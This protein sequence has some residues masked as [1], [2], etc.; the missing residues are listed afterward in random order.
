M[1]FNSKPVFKIYFEYPPLHFCQNI[2]QLTIR[3]LSPQPF[4]LNNAFKFIAKKKIMLS[5]DDA[6]CGPGWT[7][8]L[9]KIV[10]RFTWPLNTNPNFPPRLHKEK[11][12]YLIFYEL[13]NADV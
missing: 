12:N 6:R 11:M 5:S 8:S 9:S 3:T 2:S 10:G 4:D 1:P 7:I 13:I